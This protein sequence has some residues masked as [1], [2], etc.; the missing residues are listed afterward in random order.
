ME[1][2]RRRGFARG[3]RDGEEICLDSF[4]QIVSLVVEAGGNGVG[5]HVLE[6]T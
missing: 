5:F 4:R 3:G 6:I 1:G 2:R